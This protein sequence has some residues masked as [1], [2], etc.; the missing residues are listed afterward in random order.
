MSNK[1][2]RDQVADLILKDALGNDLVVLSNLTYIDNSIVF[3]VGEDKPDGDRY[4]ITL[5][6]EEV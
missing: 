6:V 1:I 4:K 3:I 5:K 2:Y